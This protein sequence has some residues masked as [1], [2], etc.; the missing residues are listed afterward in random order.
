MIKKTFLLLP[1]VL[2]FTACSNKDVQVNSNEVRPNEITLSYSEYKN[3]YES[4]NQKVKN[5][6]IAKY[7]TIIS[8][9][10]NKQLI[11]SDNTE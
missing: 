10:Q 4:K 2:L 9:S 11:L 7:E 5:K 1:V 8:P 3:L 6:P